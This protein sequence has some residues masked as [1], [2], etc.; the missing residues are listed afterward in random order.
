MNGVE[1]RA[2]LKAIAAGLPDEPRPP[3]SKPCKYNGSFNTGF[4]PGER[5]SV[6]AR[7]SRL[8][9]RRPPCRKMGMHLSRTGAL[10]AMQ[11]IRRSAILACLAFL[12]AAPSARA[13]TADD[14]RLLQIAGQS[15]SY[16]DEVR[17]LLA[18][19][20]NPNS[21]GRGGRTAVHVA[22]GNGA[23]ENMRALLEAG[24]KPNV[25]D[26]DGNTPLHFAADAIPRTGV[27]SAG[28][29]I[30]LLLEAGGDPNR[31]NAQGRTP[32][33]HAAGAPLGEGPARALLRGGADA[34][35]K[36]RWGNTPLH[37]AVGPNL[38]RPAMVQALLTGGGNPKVANGDG[39]TVLQLFVRVAGD[40]GD[41]AAMLIDAGADPSRK[42]PNGEAPLHAAIRTGGNRGKVRVA[43]ALLAGGAD[44]CARDGQ[45][46]IPY[47]VARE[48]G[49]I[50]RALSN[51]G[52]YDRACDRKGERV[53]TGSARTMQA[54][55]R[56]SVRSGPGTQYEKVGLL[57]A[58]Q[59]VR[60]TGEDGEWARI[61][62][63]QGG[64]AFVHASFLVEAGAQA[65]V[66]PKCAGLEKGAKCWKETANQRGCHVWDTYFLADRTVTWSG[67][68]PGGVASGRGTLVWTREGKSTE[69]AGAL[70]RG[71]KQGKWTVRY[72]NGTA[73]EG[74]Y[75]NGKANG[76]FVIRYAT[77]GVD[78]GEAVDGQKHGRWV[79]RSKHGTVYEGP[80]V[81]GKKHGQWSVRYK[82]GSSSE[83]TYENGKK[84]G[85][86]VDRF[87]SGA[88]SEGTYVNGEYHGQW[89][90]RG[91]DGGVSEGPY[92]KGKRHGKWV[93]RT[94]GKYGSAREGTYENGK[95]HGRWVVRRANGTVEEGPYVNGKRHGRWVWRS[96]GRSLWEGPYV[97]GKMHGH[98][99]IRYDDDGS[100]QEGSYAEGR[101]QGRWVTRYKDGRCKVSHYAGGLFPESK[102]KC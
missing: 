4:N 15:G 38:G 93:E 91:K 96:A 16:V 34:N 14:S 52:G 12:V 29:I 32:L 63:P 60:V 71:K 100:V 20:A 1:P 26:E 83:G 68:C 81:R 6:G 24:G 21:P 56:V 75:V 43:K 87:A 28:A 62:G 85:R 7:G 64:E 101:R 66:D 57:E 44:P 37:T 73:M 3:H 61:E 89:V 31:A 67:G 10:T 25:Q 48:G 76:R 65:A 49:D 42:Y 94:V 30:R 18:K 98:W 51:A 84:H 55:A 40:Q 36:D 27:D 50:H 54:R 17:A 59:E 70:A 102:S 58:G 33:H 97:Q 90:H 72:A 88:S 53:A 86:W 99:V 74:S 13:Q 11:S 69:Q 95:K 22:A 23:V 35:R 79:E 39:L 2:C 9:E 45:G 82:S 19:G 41:T 8:T 46:Y 78:E 80:Y 92:V 47:S 77:G 5:A